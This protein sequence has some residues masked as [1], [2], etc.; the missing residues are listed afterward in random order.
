M[1][2]RQML[3]Q[4]LSQGLDEEI[5]YSFS[6]TPWGSSPTSIAAKAFDVTNDN[7][8]DVTA[9]VLPAGSASAA[10]DV[11]SLPVLKA[12]TYGHIYRIEVLFTSGGNK[13]EPFFFVRAEQ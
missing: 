8:T 10:G 1:T 4:D 9:T 5:I 3:E 7:R 11:I 13:Y 2:D 12:L 6:S